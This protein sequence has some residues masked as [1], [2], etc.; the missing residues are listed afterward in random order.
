[1]LELDPGKS[2]G[3]KSSGLYRAQGLRAYVVQAVALPQH[4]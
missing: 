4:G 1:M 2:A 3:Q